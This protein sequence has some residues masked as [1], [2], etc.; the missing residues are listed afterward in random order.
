MGKRA[1]VPVYLRG[2]LKAM[3]YLT[4]TMSRPKWTRH[5]GHTNMGMMLSPEGWRNP[6]TPYA[7]DNGVFARS[8]IGTRPDAGWWQ[9]EGET[10]WLKMLDKIPT[11]QPPLFVLLPDV[12]L[13]WPATMA[14]AAVY[15]RE[16]NGRRL[17]CALA[18]QDGCDFR[19]V[20]RF[21]PHAVFVGGSTAW[22]WANVRRIVCAF[23]PLGIHVHVGRVN[24]KAHLW[25]CREAGVNSCDGTGISRHTDAMK[26]TVMTG[27]FESDPQMRLF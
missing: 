17:S 3:I 23:A 15:R 26:P 8:P 18:L 2:V 1:T 22:K 5:F 20:F 7:C 27:L 12:V 13:D 21:A 25:H 4:G 6:F 19:D 16:V 10:A 11:N 24:G 14:R 9:R